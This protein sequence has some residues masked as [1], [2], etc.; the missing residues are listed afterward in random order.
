MM[1]YCESLL[2]IVIKTYNLFVVLYNNHL[3]V[4]PVNVDIVFL[5]EAMY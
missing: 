5:L 1:S 4:M 2:R 3:S